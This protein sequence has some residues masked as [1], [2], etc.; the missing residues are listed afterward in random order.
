M[1]RCFLFILLVIS[2]CAVIA[3]NVLAYQ[4]SAVYYLVDEKETS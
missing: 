4:F 2:A 3:Q 1:F